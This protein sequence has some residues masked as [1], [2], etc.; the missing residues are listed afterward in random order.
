MS[1]RYCCATAHARW[2]GFASAMFPSPVP[3]S[4]ISTVSPSSFVPQT[5]HLSSS[6]KCWK[7]RGCGLTRRWRQ[8]A[9][10]VSFLFIKSLVAGHRRS[11]MS[12]LG[13]LCRLAFKAFHA[14]QASACD[15]LYFGAGWSQF[16][17]SN[18]ISIVPL[19]RSRLVWIG[20]Y[21]QDG[22]TFGSARHSR[23]I[24]ESVG[25]TPCTATAGV[26]SGLDG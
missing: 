11:P 23:T 4:A 19:F 13:M 14:A 1:C 6:G 9:L 25:T 22:H 3:S 15:G 26:P 16:G 10:D 8:S 7:V 21:P 20:M 17:H 5:G 18:R 12:Q 2:N 24:L